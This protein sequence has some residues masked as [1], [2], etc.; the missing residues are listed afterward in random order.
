MISHIDYQTHHI[1]EQI[2]PT[3]LPCE[4]TH[5]CHHAFIEANDQHGV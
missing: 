5:S 1:Q 4:K 3:S 2:E